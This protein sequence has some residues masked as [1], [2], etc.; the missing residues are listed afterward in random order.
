MRIRVC[1]K[2]KQIDVQVGDGS[3]QMKWL[4]N[5]ALCRYDTNFG[6]ELGAPTG[7]RTE[8]GANVPLETIIKD[9]LHDGDQVFVQLAHEETQEDGKGATDTEEE[10]ETEQDQGGEEN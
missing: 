3:Q 7:I 4:A 9:R 6:I 5:A 2:D 10:T 8:D 1:I